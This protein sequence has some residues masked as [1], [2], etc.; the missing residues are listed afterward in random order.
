MAWYARHYLPE[1]AAADPLASPLRAP[2]L[3]GL[4]PALVIT[5]EYDPPRDQGE[6]Y[7]HRLAEAGVPVEA[8]R[9]PGMAHGFFA[10][11]GAVDAATTA[12]LQSARHPRHCFGLPVPD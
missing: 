10:M 4:P 11:A 12:H 1:R 7:S 2:T 6:A 3:S 5:A 9:Y 8:T